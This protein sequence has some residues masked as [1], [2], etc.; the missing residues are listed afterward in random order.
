MAFPWAAASFGLGALSF[1]SGA[2]KS[3]KAQAAQ[4][5]AFKMGIE[6]K[7]SAY[8]R[9]IDIANINLSQLQSSK[10]FS[11]WGMEQQHAQ[12]EKDV[13]AAIGA[14]GAALGA[15]TPLDY[16]NAMYEA[17]RRAREEQ[18]QFFGYEEEKIASDIEWFE[19]EIGR[20]EDILNP[21][22]SEMHKRAEQERKKSYDKRS[23]KG[24]TGEGYKHS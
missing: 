17:Q 11:I 4:E 6:D 12:M 22:T 20:Y 21:K 24:H 14:S 23:A 13:K 15:G 5:E 8:Q 3:S 9:N 1:I 7:I 19:S 18:E 16:M 2:S 10:E